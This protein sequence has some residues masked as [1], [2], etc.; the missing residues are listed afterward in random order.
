MMQ[1]KNRTA[2][3]TPFE[4]RTDFRHINLSP[5]SVRAQQ[6]R[7]KEEEYTKNRAEDGGNEPASLISMPNEILSKIFWLSHELWLIHTCCRIH[8]DL[9]SYQQTAITLQVW[10]FCDLN[11]DRPHI[12]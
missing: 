3:D 6:R 5:S 7:D 2:F 10:A 11:L 4:T 8:N 12:S 1:P 9:P